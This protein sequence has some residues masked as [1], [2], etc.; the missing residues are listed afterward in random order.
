M[1]LT[2]TT[3][4][5]II[6]E[7]VEQAAM[8]QAPKK[9]A[10]EE[11]APKMVSKPAD[12]RGWMDVDYPDVPPAKVAAVIANAMDIPVM[13]KGR[14][15]GAWLKDTRHW[16]EPYGYPGRMGVELPFTGAL[17][18]SFY[19]EIRP[20]HLKEMGFTSV[21]Q[22]STFLRDQGSKQ[23]SEDEVEAKPLEDKVRRF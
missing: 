20:T 8:T 1:K 3:L 7:E 2:A 18:G 16:S 11:P 9:K 19:C 17:E 13:A 10:P 23:T 15:S 6:R 14:N 21:A 12:K 22:L 5:R 4:R